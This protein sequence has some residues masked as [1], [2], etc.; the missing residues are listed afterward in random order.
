MKEFASSI[1]A[2]DATFDLIDNVCEILRKHKAYVNK[3]CGLHIHLGMSRSTE[4]QR[5][6]IN[7]WW[8]IFE[9]VFFAIVSPSRRAN[10]Y[11]N[12]TTAVSEDNRYRS[13]N[14]CSYGV[15][16]TFEV[17][18]HQ[19]SLDP[20]KIKHWISVLL[21]FF[22]TFSKIP[23]TPIRVNR[24]KRLDQRELLIYFYNKLKLK[25]DL[26]KYVL[27]RIKEFDKGLGYSYKTIKNLKKKVIV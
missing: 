9:P 25:L 22:D 15:H 20:H 2:G 3:S 26:R 10:E 11:T 27:S 21:S 18:L 13:L 14:I 17:R 7:Q 23:P 19:G 24:V 1:T 12:W 5:H 16:E 4:D 8:S 6:F